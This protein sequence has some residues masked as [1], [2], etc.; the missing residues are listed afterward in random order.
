MKNRVYFFTGTGNSLHLARRIAERLGDCEIIAIHK[1]TDLNVPSE[2]D[3]VGF[4]FPVYFWGLPV[5]VADFLRNAV[6]PTQGDTYV[7]A[8]ATFGGIV[9]NA[10]PQIKHLLGDKGI[11]LNYGA[12]VRSFANAVSFYEMKEDI[13]KIVRKTEKRMQPVLEAIT[14]RRVKKVGNGLKQIEKMYQKNAPLFAKRAN[15]Y[16]VSDDCVSCGICA[17]V[18][19]AQNF[20]AICGQFLVILLN[21]ATDG[22]YVNLEE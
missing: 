8:V 2:F 9:G 15:A 21:V 16:I 20:V 13:D 1:G 11:K 19:P 4:V 10:I 3:R 12:A 17:S 7:F 18:C 6:F 14:A 5:M 22:T